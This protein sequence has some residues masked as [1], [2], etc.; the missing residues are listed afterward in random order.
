MFYVDSFTTPRFDAHEC[1]S[2]N[3][4]TRRRIMHLSSVA[5]FSLSA[6]F[7]MF[8]IFLD[9]WDDSS[10]RRAIDFAVDMSTFVVCC[11]RRGR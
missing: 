3:M 4:D 2:L 9:V 5:F 1:L 7:F 6:I 10:D 8:V 11:T